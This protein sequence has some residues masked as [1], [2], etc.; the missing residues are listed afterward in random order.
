MLDEGVVGRKLGEQI[1]AFA[2]VRTLAQMLGLRLHR[3]IVRDSG[4]VVEALCESRI[5]E[6]R[7]PL[8]VVVARA[9]TS[10]R[11]PRKLTN[12]RRIALA[13]ADPA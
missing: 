12:E 3:C 11:R 8:E 13:A 10:N 9:H 2:V 5:D 7:E 1:R 4:D 6:R